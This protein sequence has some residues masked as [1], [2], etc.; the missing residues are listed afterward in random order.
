ML[1]KG[2]KGRK[3]YKYPIQG[4]THWGRVTHIYIGNQTIVASDNGL[5]PGRCQAIIW[6]S[7]GMLLIWPLGTN[8]S[9]NSHRNSNIFNA[10]ENVVWKMAAILSRPQCVKSAKQVRYLYATIYLTFET[11][12]LTIGCN[13]CLNCLN[14]KW[15]WNRLFEK[16]DNSG[17]WIRLSENR[18]KLEIASHTVWVLD[19]VIERYDYAKINP[20][21]TNRWLRARLQ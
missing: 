21:I 5:Y 10:F 8:F 4:L 2:A 14:L 17:S 6:T 7:A 19:P 1:V 9:W 13:L 15:T 11:F 20:T 16:S 18:S 3:G 12:D